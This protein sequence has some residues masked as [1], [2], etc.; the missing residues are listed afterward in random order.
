MSNPLLP[1]TLLMLGDRTFSLR[2]DFEAIAQ[3]EEIVDRPLLTGLRQRDIS[4]PT[5]GLVRAMLFASLHAGYPEITFDQVKEMVT[6]K[7]LVDIWT[8]VLSA[9]VDSAQVPD[10]ER[11]TDETAENPTIA[12]LN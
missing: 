11:D 7:N 6:R 4:T 9:W 2:F 10:E 12:R 8:K 3:A 1:V 5:I